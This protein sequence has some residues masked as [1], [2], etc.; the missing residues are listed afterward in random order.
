[1]EIASEVEQYKEDLKI[2]N[3]FVIE[4]DKDLLI[5]LVNFES[6]K[7]LNINKI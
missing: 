4:I 3:D 2:K 1:M 7:G 5:S 6:I